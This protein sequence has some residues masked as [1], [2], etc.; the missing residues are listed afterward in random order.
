MLGR[1]DIARGFEDWGGLELV[2]NESVEL[3]R[4]GGRSNEGARSAALEGWYETNVDL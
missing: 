4:G 1:L 2:G 3:G